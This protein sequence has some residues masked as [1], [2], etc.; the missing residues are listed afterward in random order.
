M[1]AYDTIYYSKKD[2]N[3]QK[4]QKV[5][6][7]QI[8]DAKVKMLSATKNEIKNNKLLNFASKWATK[9]DRGSYRVVIARSLISGFML[10]II[11]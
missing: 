7:I 8:K 6:M 4:V 10:L 11:A 9:K 1:L 3:D 5:S 2:K